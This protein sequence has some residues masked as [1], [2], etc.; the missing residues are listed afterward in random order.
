MLC[1]YRTLYTVQYTRVSRTILAAPCC[2]AGWSITYS[3]PDMS[4]NSHTLTNIMPRLY[5][6]LR[7][8]SSR[9]PFFWWKGEAAFLECL[10]L[11]FMQCTDPV[12]LRICCELMVW[13]WLLRTTSLAEI[14]IHNPD[15]SSTSDG[16]MCSR[17][18][19]VQ[20]S[21]DPKVQWRFQSIHHV[22]H[23]QESNSFH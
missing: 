13:M 18:Q 15:N 21:I 5:M 8:F 12:T 23:Y 14:W 22:R 19:D 1:W 7:D 10:T 4:P 17:S 3:T 6:R 20:W 9:K 2:R 11:F 16:Y